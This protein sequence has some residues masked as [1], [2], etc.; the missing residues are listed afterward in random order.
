MEGPAEVF[1]DNNSVFNNSIIPTLL[2]NNIHNYISYHRV[3]E[4]QASGV[5][6]VGWIS[7]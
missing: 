5:L 7:W 4:A 3:R 6:R 2:L 1:G